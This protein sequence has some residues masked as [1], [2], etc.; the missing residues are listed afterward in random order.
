VSGQ[1]PREIE[2][3]FSRA[4]QETGKIVR[5][6]LHDCAKDAVKR[7]VIATLLAGGAALVGG[8]HMALERIG[9]RKKP[10]PPMAFPKWETT[11]TPASRSKLMRP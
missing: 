5:E 8:G 9:L 10:E 4:R 7:I 6:A 11:V 1:T 2:W 3:P